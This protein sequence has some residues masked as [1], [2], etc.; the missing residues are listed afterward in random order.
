MDIEGRGETN[1]RNQESRHEIKNIAG[2]MEQVTLQR[3]NRNGK[4]QKG[5]VKSSPKQCH[6]STY[7]KKLEEANKLWSQQTV[8]SRVLCLLFELFFCVFSAGYPNGAFVCAFL[9]L[10]CFVAI[11]GLMFLSLLLVAH[12][13]SAWFK[14]FDRFDVQVTSSFPNNHSS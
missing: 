4:M 7:K 1:K 3:G 8:R 5:A 14:A 2:R 11:L 10:L 9:L 12:L 13:V 6:V